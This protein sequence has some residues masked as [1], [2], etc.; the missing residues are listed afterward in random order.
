MLQQA[1]PTVAGNDGERMFLAQQ[2]V[3]MRLRIDRDTKVLD[4]GGAGARFERGDVTVVDIAPPAWDGAH[5]VQLD[6]CR[7]RLPFATGEFDVCICTQTLEDLY[8]PFLVLD[9]M[10][11]VARRGYIETPHRGLESSFAV[12]A[13][14]GGYPGWGH[15]RWMFEVVNA[16]RFRVVPKTWQLLRHDARKV[17]HW[18]GPSLFEFFWEGG[19]EYEHVALMDAGGDHWHPMLAEH[20]EFVGR[21]AHLLRTLEDCEAD[22][23]AAPGELEPHVRRPARQPSAPTSV[24]TW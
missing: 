5:F 23:A 13:H 6:V 14:Q 10:R 20:N 18:S 4:I 7:E 15:H 11:R 19:Y 21:H 24:A 1:E 12:S 8:D 16:R 3:A 2:W 22:R 17:V 9:E